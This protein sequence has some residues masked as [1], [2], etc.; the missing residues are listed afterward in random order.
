MMQLFRTDCYTSSDM[1]ASA[2]L[3]TPLGHLERRYIINSGDNPLRQ[4]LPCYRHLSRNCAIYQWAS[5]GYVLEE[6]LVQ[7]TPAALTRPADIHCQALVVRLQAMASVQAFDGELS[8]LPG[9][10]W[11]DGFGEPGEGLEA[12]CWAGDVGN[13]TIGTEDSEYLAVRSRSEKWMP[14]RL[15][16]Y[17]ETHKDDVVKVRRDSL[18]IH[19]PELEVGERVQFQFVI[20]SGP[21]KDDDTTLWLAV[22]QPPD[23]LLAAGDCT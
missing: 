23:A 15:A 19:L 18:S 16:A 4:Q 17:F 22:D 5:P 20:A 7:F 10:R 2:Q 1:N 11:T 3:S 14:R 21:R 13:V 8:W 9:Y 12:R 6:L